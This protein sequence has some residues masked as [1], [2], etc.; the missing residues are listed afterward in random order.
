MSKEPTQDDLRRLV[1]REVHYCVSSLVHTLAQGYGRWQEPKEMR[2]LCEQA[3]ELSVPVPDYEE[4]ARQSDVLMQQ[5]DG[6]WCSVAEASDLTVD[7]GRTLYDS[8]EQACLEHDIEPYEWEVYEHW[9]VSDWLAGKLEEQGEKVDRDFA[10]L[11][12]WARTTTGQAI[13]LDSVIERIWRNL[14][15]ADPA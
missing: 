8:A 2:E 9:I 4:A 10:G 11:T 12:V 3:F 7:E 13:L 6:K 15:T 1:D 14:H 5:E